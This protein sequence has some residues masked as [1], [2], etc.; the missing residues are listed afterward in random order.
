M[1]KKTLALSKDVVIKPIMVEF[2]TRTVM[3]KL[4]NNHVCIIHQR[5]RKGIQ[6]G[7][8]AVPHLRGYKIVASNNASGKTYDALL[9]GY[10]VVA[11]Q[12]SKKGSQ[13]IAKDYTPDTPKVEYVTRKVA[14]T[15]PDGHQRTVTQRVR[16]G[17]KF[18][19]VAVS[20]LRGYVANV[21]GDAKGLNDLGVTA[22]NGDF[23]FLVIS[24][25]F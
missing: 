14:I 17:T 10:H 20:K 8:V 18:G 23:H 5:V 21:S 12:D 7:K 3:I 2:V 15:M 13:L 6:F 11:D 19:R 24:R 22:A 25:F 9:S 1:V 4:P 16:K